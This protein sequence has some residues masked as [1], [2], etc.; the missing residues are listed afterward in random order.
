MLVKVV[1]VEDPWVGP[2][3]QGLTLLNHYI[4]EDLEQTLIG[5]KP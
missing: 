3:P 5:M 4:N 1:E 2:S